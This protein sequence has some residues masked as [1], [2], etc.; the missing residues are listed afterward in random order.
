MF[1]VVAIISALCFNLIFLCQLYHLLSNIS[2]FTASPCTTIKYIV[3]LYLT[4]CWVDAH[5]LQEAQ[6]C[7]HI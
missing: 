6:Y 7:V 5:E 4:A 2:Y 1:L 3:H